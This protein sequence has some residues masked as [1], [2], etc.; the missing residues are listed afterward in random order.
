M[1]DKIEKYD[2][3]LKDIGMWNPKVVLEYYLKETEEGLV[4]SQKKFIFS[5]KYLF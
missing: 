5:I 1:P 4:L 2:A 3:T